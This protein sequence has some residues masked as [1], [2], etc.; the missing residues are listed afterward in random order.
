[1]KQGKRQFEGVAINMPIEG[2]AVGVARAPIGIPA[3]FQGRRIIFDVAAATRYPQGK[4][5]LL[6]F[7]NGLRV[8][9]IGGINGSGT[10]EIAVTIAALAAGGIAIS[11]PTH[12]TCT[13]PQGVAEA[14]PAELAPTMEVWWKPGDSADGMEEKLR[15]AAAPA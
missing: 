10:G 13:A 4:G 9:G 7:R 15:S 5:S 3:K 12:I 11:R 14:T 8:G 2:G 6:R 1:M